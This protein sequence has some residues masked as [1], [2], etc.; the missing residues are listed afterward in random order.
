VD[1]RREDATGI[2]YDLIGGSAEPHHERL[3][4]WAFTVS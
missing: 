1:A 2:P 4:C 3:K